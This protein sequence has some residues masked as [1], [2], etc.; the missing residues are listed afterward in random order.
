L[1]LSQLS[2]PKIDCLLLNF[3]DEFH[4]AVNI[5]YHNPIFSSEEVSLSVGNANRQSNII[6]TE[7]NEL[8]PMQKQ[9]VAIILEDQ[10]LI[11]PAYFGALKSSKHVI[12]VDTSTPEE[13]QNYQVSDA[14]IG[15]I[16][17]NSKII[18]QIKSQIPKYIKLIN[19]DK[20]NWDLSLENPKIVYSVDNLVQIMY[21][22]GSTG[23]PK[24]VMLD[25]YQLIHAISL[26]KKDFLPSDKVSMLK[27]FYF[28]A[29]II[30]LFCAVFAGLEIVFYDLQKSGMVGF[31]E[32]IKK[33]EVT[34]LSVTA[35]LFRKFVHTLDET[36]IFPKVRMLGLGAEKKLKQDLVNLRKH[37]DPS[38]QI[39]LGFACTEAMTATQ[40]YFSILH[41]FEHDILPAGEPRDFTKIIIWDENR[42]ELAQG[43]EGEIVVHSKSISKG[44]WKNEKLTNEKFIIDLNLPRYKFYR[45]GDLGKILPDG[46]LQHLGRLDHMVKI[47]GTRI[48]LESIEAHTLSYPGIIQ[49]ASKIFTD[50]IGNQRLTTYYV[51]EE[52]ITI[53]S[54]DLRMHLAEKLTIQMMPHFL[55]RI[56]ELPLTSSGKIN[57]LKLPPPNMVRPDISTPYEKAKTSI[58]SKVLK[59]WE[60]NLAISGIGINDNF[61]DVGG[62][63]LI[64]SLILLD[65]EKL[66]GKNLPVSILLMA[67]TI[68]KQSLMI[69]NKTENKYNKILINVKKGNKLPP[70]FFIPGKGGHPTRISYLANKL[71]NDLPI[72]AFQEV[73]SNKYNDIEERIDKFIIE[74]RKIQPKGP[75]FLLGESGGGNYCYEIARRL[76]EKGDKIPILALLDTYN[77]KGKN[78]K[79][80]KEMSKF[81]FVR[82]LINKHLTIW[83][84]SSWTGKKD[85][86]QYYRK[87]FSKRFIWLIKF[88]FI[89]IK[90][91]VPN[92]QK[93]NLPSNKL[94]N[95]KYYSGNVIL[96]KATRGKYQELI[97]NGW[98][99][100]KI[101]KLIIHQIDCYHG[102]ILF[103]PAVTNVSMILNNYIN[104]F[105]LED[106]NNS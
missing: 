62:D 16:I 103:E 11:I 29:P 52:H 72:Y 30:T 96:F 71:N 64:A 76:T 95:Q 8:N 68:R 55:I 42:K 51:A 81:I 33:S 93:D 19:T 90:F 39:R 44:Y 94:L 53:P 27:G 60:D 86:L 61:F 83:K 56:P 85:Y 15:I 69:E 50:K 102:G 87:E 41:D 10:N 5:N 78:I 28:P 43:L 73:K 18:N 48:E 65:I 4:N 14:E 74:I 25:Y 84:Q 99:K 7:I 49:V 12:I 45:S 38:C 26:K 100:Q 36:T 47:K 101:G 32:W 66:F 22:S 88:N 59:I 98:N 91:Q 79:Y 31:S 58:E 2:T 57:P 9:G 63:S 82:T 67:D 13:R 21:T 34:Y 89:K 54:S 106:K 104:D 97:S 20:I 24:G 23:N 46:Q 35:S 17:S 1:K 37:F 80:K 105:I 92:I 77:F 6:V 70:L 3:W 75:H 40:S